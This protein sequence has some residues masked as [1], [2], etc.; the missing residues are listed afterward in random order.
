MDA[1]QSPREIDSMWPLWNIFDLAPN[2]RSET[3]WPRLD[4]AD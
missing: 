2:V 1:G 4:Y 3:W